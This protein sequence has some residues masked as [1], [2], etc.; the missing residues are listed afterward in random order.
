MHGTLTPF[1]QF[2]GGLDLLVHQV[3]DKPL[4]SG[5]MCWNLPFQSC[6]SQHSLLSLLCLASAASPWHVA[7]ANELIEVKKQ[8][9]AEARVWRQQQ[10][11]YEVRLL[12]MMM[13]IFSM[14]RCTRSWGGKLCCYVFFWHGAV[15]R[16]ISEWGCRQCLLLVGVITHVNRCC[17]GA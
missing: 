17:A 15:T 8:Q 5:H 12:L 6:T 3:R 14:I 1:P 7:Q 4:T 13:L 16:D 2:L 11:E 9:L 10:E